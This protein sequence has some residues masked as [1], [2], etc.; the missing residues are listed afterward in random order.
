MNQSTFSSKL[1]PKRDASCY[2]QLHVGVGL[3]LP[4]KILVFPLNH[5]NPYRKCFWSWKRLDR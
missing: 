1:R 3:H 5:L 2:S 4:S